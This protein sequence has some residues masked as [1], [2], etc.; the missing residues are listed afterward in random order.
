L[1]RFR[2][3]A[4]FENEFRQREVERPAAPLPGR[5][6]LRW[7]EKDRS[8]PGV[9]V[10]AVT[11]GGPAARA[12]IRGGDRLLAWNGSPLADGDQL[13]SLVLAAEGPVQV[14]FSRTG[15]AEPQAV[16]LTLSGKPVR[17]GIAWRVDDAEPGTVILTR[18]VPGSPADKAGLRVHDR[19]YQ[20]GGADFADQREFAARLQAAEGPLELVYERL[21]R[22]G[23]A[24][25]ALPPV[26]SH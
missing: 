14:S 22:L 5:L 13:R 15:Q 8:A 17:V 11:P 18:V 2:G 4:T 10:A 1:P 7:D 25:L 6:G 9:K 24:V 26:T 16:P 21:G 12:G 3:P 19:I 23:T 20:V